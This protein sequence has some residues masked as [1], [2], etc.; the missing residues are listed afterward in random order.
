AGARAYG[1]SR[2]GR[3]AWRPCSAGSFV[4][5]GILAVAQL[6]PHDALA[7]SVRV[8]APDDAAQRTRLPGPLGI[9]VESKPAVNTRELL[10]P[11]L[12]R[13]TAA[14]GERLLHAQ[15]PGIRVH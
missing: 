5:S 7:R 15:H 14:R 13:E 10:R 2:S 11:L 3:P 9:L 6:D 4:T 1:R 12:L 8:G